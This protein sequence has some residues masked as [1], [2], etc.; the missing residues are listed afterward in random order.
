MS[1]NLRI[2]YWNCRDVSKKR[3]EL[4]E[5]V[6]RK[7][8]DIILLNE[9]H[10]NNSQQFKLPNYHSY[11]TN[12]LQRLGNRPWGGTAILIN[13]KI[14][15]HQI[16]ITTSSLENTSIQIQIGN[17]EL[18]LS[19]VY[20]RPDT[21]LLTS[22]LDSL[23]NTSHYVVIA[24]DLNAKH[25]FWNSR[26]H[27]T[28]GSTLAKFSDKRRDIT[29]AAPTSPT[30][31]PDNLNHNGD[32]LDVAILKTGKLRYTIGKISQPKSLPIIPL[33]FFNYKSMALKPYHPKLLNTQ[34]GPSSTSIQKT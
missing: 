30:H 11:I 17:K 2:L 8:I 9:T 14:V 34:I 7:N 27:N 18:R 6:Q 15:H 20:K 29:I 24:G 21:P 22:D 28:A 1:N 25:Q 33:S 10:L 5:L 4:L 23:L 26:R 16:K 13:R 32:I 3:L 12:R 19:A 31:Y